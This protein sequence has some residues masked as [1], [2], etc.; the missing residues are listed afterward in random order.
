MVNNGCPSGTCFMSIK[1][2]LPLCWFFKSSFIN[3][4]RAFSASEVE[5]LL[6]NNAGHVRVLDNLSNGYYSN[7]E[8][9]I[10]YPN[11][12][13]IEV[14]LTLAISPVIPCLTNIT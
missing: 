12:E 9:F 1:P 13:F 8:K 6:K 14:I 4:C 5:Y 7:I 3:N 10:N 2:E 11:F